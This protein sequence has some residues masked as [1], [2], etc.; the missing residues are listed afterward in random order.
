MISNSKLIIL[1]NQV[2][3]V[4]GVTGGEK[5]LFELVNRW[6]NLLPL[7]VIMPRIGMPFVDKNI[8]DHLCIRLPLLFGRYPKSYLGV[9]I[10]WGELA[11]R[12]GLLLGS[13]KK[14][15]GIIYTSADFF[16][17]TIPATMATLRHKNVKWVG[18]VHH[19]REPPGKRVSR[20]SW[21]IDAGAFI[22]Q[23][24][25]FLLLRR[26][27]ICIFLLNQNVKQ[28]LEGM[29]FDPSRLYVTGAGID[30]R[31]ISQSTPD[32]NQCYDA[33]FLGRLDPTKGIRELI[34]VWAIVTKQIPNVKLALIGQTSQEE[35]HLIKKYVAKLNLENSVS[36]L[37]FLPEQEKY[38]I[39]KASKIYISLSFE[40]GWGMA[41]TEAMACGLPVVAWNLPVYSELYGDGIVTTVSIGD[42]EGADDRI[43]IL[44]SDEPRRKDLAQR[45]IS[46]A[47]RYDFDVVGEKQWTLIQ[48]LI[49]G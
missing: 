5:L 26:Y 43:V 14:S 46:V 47:L 10:R 8:S 41:I 6:Q 36:F 9:L 35:L 40:E 7:C 45:G 2:L 1:A 3:P 37:G 16:C 23:Q 19:V 15:S 17:N 44:L 27:A 25:S 13:L 21:L 28:Q 42:I 38:A 48:N 20:N 33:C 30:T 18:V 32:K 12:T 24:V 31:R 34:S 39:M 4:E 49:S 29:G 22:M 11:F